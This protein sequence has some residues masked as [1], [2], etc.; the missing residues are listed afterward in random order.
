MWL[1]RIFGDAAETDMRRCG[2]DG[3]MGKKFPLLFLPHRRRCTGKAE[4]TKI[5]AKSRDGSIPKNVGIGVDSESILYNKESILFHDSLAKNG[6]KIVSRFPGFGFV[7]ALARSTKGIAMGF[8]FIRPAAINIGAILSAC[9]T[10]SCPESQEL[11]EI[12]DH[13]HHKTRETPNTGW[14]CRMSHRKWNNRPTQE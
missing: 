6:K 11:R 14:G 3:K 10:W 2:S 9:G 7:P 4:T 5:N 13:R 1:W 8:T 12:V